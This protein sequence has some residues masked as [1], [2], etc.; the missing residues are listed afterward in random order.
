[1]V[2]TFWPLITHS[3]PSSSAWVFSEA[4]SEPLFGS[5]K[6]WH[7][8]IVPLRMRGRNSFFCSSV[9]HCRIVGPTSVSPKKSA[10]SGALRRA[11]SSA[12]T[13]PCIVD[14]PLP[15]YSFG[16]VAQIQP[17]S[18]SFCGHASLNV[19]RS[20]GVISKSSAPQPSGRLASSQP[21]ISVRKASASA[22]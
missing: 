6:P 22:S 16:Q 7:Q 15:P 5:L 18:N 14:R 1:M 17:P 12:R 2:H 9:P 8:R 4:R 20:C 19:A 11:N 13:T 10:R 21:R 3:S